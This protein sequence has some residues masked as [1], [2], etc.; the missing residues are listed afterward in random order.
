MINRSRF[1]SELERSRIPIHTQALSHAVGAL[2]ALAV[3]EPMHVAEE[4][5]IQARNLLDM[6]ELEESGL[7]LNNINTLQTCILL[8]YYEL[9]KPTFNRAWMMLARAIRL[10]KIMRLECVDI[11]TR[12]TSAQPSSP[13]TAPADIEERR[14]TFWQLYILD[15]LVDMGNSW[16]TVFENVSLH[17]THLNEHNTWIT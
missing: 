15:S 14:R 16:G 7:M 11:A 5:Y 12:T 9:K 2:S 8:V 1:H 6:C 10:S 4:S 3:P 17:P 13:L